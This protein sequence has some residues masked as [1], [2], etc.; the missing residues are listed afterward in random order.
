MSFSLYCSLGLLLLTTGCAEFSTGRSYLSEMDHD[1][2]RFFSPRDDFPVV[3]GDS[4]RDWISTKERRQRTPASVEDGLEDRAS[5]AL[6][7][8]LREL[9]GLQS[10][11]SLALYQEH[12]HLLS[13]T[14]HKIYFLKLPP[15]ERR[16]Y[17]ASRGLLSEKKSALEIP[18][19]RASSRKV[20]D[21]YLGMNKS[22]VLASMG[23]PVK[24][25]IA[26][27]PRNENERWL[28]HFNSQSKFIYFESGRVEGW[29]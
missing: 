11:D 7:T 22:E 9:E 23:K 2:S 19:K 17:L 13:G 10:E 12:K 14:S 21:V 25:E 8:E 1:D 16:D 26:G 20:N 29:E 18:W 6:K 15:N 27:N 28:Y 4:G 24:V 5:R 3:A